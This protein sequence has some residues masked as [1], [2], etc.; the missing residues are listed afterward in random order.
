VDACHL[1]LHKTFCIP[2]GGGGPGVGP[3]AVAESLVPFLPSEDPEKENHSIQVGM[4][5]SAPQGSAGIL[6]IPWMYLRMMGAEGLCH[7]TARAILHAN[8][9][10]HRLDPYF[11]VL[12]RSRRGWVAHECI[13]DLRGFKLTTAEDVA[14]RLIDFGFHAPTLSWPVAG[15]LMVEPTESEDRGELD[16]FCDAMIA[17]HEE[18]RAVESGAM[19]RLNNPLK[20][21]PHPAGVVC[22]ESWDRPYSRAQAAFPLEWV[23]QRKTWP[24]VSR[25]D[26]VWGDRNLFCSC[27]PPA[28]PE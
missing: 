11:P 15:T 2:H 28:L 26:N 18:M 10:A 1:N 20:N 17:I 24:A 22:A 7:A 4:V 25:V 16:R 3:I 12:Y 9:I 19:D 14:K 5:C 23:R 27:A 8:Y 13:L 6:A 21:A